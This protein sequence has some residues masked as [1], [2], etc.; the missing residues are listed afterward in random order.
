MQRDYDLLDQFTAM[1]VERFGEDLGIRPEDVPP[2]KRYRQHCTPKELSVLDRKCGV[3]GIPWALKKKEGE[4][5]RKE[6]ENRA[7][8]GNLVKATKLGAVKRD[9]ETNFEKCFICFNSYSFVK[10]GVRL[11]LWMSE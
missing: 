8:K 9:I 4:N 10:K 7:R 2:R 6:G 11:F 1:M 5:G 3:D